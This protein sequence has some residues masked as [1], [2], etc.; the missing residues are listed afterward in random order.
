MWPDG[1]LAH[2][3]RYLLTRNH[4]K[5]STAAEYVKVSSYGGYTTNLPIED[6]TG[7]QAMVATHAAGAP[8][9]LCG[10]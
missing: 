9:T 3:R 8:L 4:S 6:V 5:Q 2:S 10:P 7:G 1:P